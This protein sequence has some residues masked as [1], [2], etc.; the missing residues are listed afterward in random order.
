MLS[1]SCERPRVWKFTTSGLQFFSDSKYEFS[2]KG[3]QRRDSVFD[4]LVHGHNQR[5]SGQSR[6]HENTKLKNVKLRDY[7]MQHVFRKVAFKKLA[8][9][10]GWWNCYFWGKIDKNNFQVRD[11]FSWRRTVRTEVAWLLVWRCTPTQRISKANA[12]RELNSIQ[13]I[14]FWI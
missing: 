6:F 12:Y 10:N 9:W 2:G 5:E 3:L 13:Y 8:I 1:R 4:R 14:Q 11:D 7:S